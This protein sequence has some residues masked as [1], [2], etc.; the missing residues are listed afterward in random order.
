MNQLD[1]VKDACSVRW[2]DAR[3]R[4]GLWG[5]M[6]LGIPSMLFIVLEWSSYD[7]QTVIAGYISLQ[8]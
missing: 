1:L 2:F 4:T 5:Y 6:K 3:N 7:I 8:D